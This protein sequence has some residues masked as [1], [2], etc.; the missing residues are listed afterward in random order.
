MDQMGIFTRHRSKGINE[1][2]DCP[3]L[4]D[5]TLTGDGTYGWSMRPSPQLRNFEYIDDTPHKLSKHILPP[6][7]V[8]H[9]KVDTSS[10]TVLNDSW[11]TDFGNFFRFSERYGVLPFLTLET[12][13]SVL[14]SL[15]NQDFFDLNREAF[16]YFADVFPTAMSFSEFIVGM[17]QLQDLIP[18]LQESM[19]KSFSGGYLNKKF[20]WDNLLSDLDTLGGVVQLVED[21]LAYLK[22]TYGIPTRLG[23]SRPN[24]LPMPSN[25]PVGVC[26]WDSYR[27]F[28][29]VLTD[30]R[31]DMRAGATILQT[32]DYLDGT[33]GLIRGLTGA[34]G[35]NNPIKALWQNL[36]FSF[37]VDWFINISDHLDT[38]TR[39]APATGWDTTNVSCSYKFRARFKVYGVYQYYTSFRRYYGEVVLDD[40]RRFI[41]LPLSLEDLLPSTE[42][43]PTQLTLLLALLHQKS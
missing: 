40:Y 10:L 11:T 6:G 1:L 16:N 20:G 22:R 37:V 14:P 33:I 35:L 31:L 39:L 13:T 5:N 24:I 15:P 38:L 27:H 7:K 34:F 9:L 42:L 29:V 30:Y 41:G 8:H 18:R 26:T 3:I 2:V 19:A 43:S 17:G 32:L 36:P 23:F 12:L 4:W 21:R 28:E 25:N